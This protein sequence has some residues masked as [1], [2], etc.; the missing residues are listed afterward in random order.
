MS[1]TRVTGAGTSC[2]FCSSPSTSLALWHRAF[3]SDLLRYSLLFSLVII[4]SSSGFDSSDSE[5]SIS[6]IGYVLRTAA[7]QSL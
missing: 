6:L 7:A 2:M 4:A 1:P 5:S 3:T